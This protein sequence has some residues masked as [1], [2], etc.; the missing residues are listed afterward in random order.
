MSEE[1]SPGDERLE[2][3][4]KEF[5]SSQ[6]KRSPVKVIED[7]VAWEEP[8]HV[9]AWA[10]ERHERGQELLHAVFSEGEVLDSITLSKTEAELLRRN[11]RDLDLR[12]SHLT[13]WNR[14][15]KIAVI[16]LGCLT[17]SMVVARYLRVW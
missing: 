15:L 6:M 2:S 10:S 11:I 16:L 1:E 14:A 12:L 3:R 4:F 9:A 13:R 8:R 17:V 7:H 5:L